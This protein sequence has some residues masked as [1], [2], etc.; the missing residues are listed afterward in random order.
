MSTGDNKN[1]LDRSVGPDGKHHWRCPVQLLLHMQS[2]RVDLESTTT[3]SIGCLPRRS[4]PSTPRGASRRALGQRLRSL[5]YQGIPLPSGTETN[6]AYC[7]MYCGL[8]LVGYGWVLQVRP[9]MTDKIWPKIPGGGNLQVRT[10]EKI[11]ERY[12]IRASPLG[13]CLVSW[14]LQPLLSHAGA[15][16]N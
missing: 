3:S 2:L 11:R 12:D 9:M 7:C 4:P 13:D 15:P 5:Q 1:A 10:R 14:C 8:A 6:D 16:R